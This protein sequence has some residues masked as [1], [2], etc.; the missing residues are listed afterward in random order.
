MRLRF[1]TIL[2]LLTTAG[3]AFAQHPHPHHHGESRVI[4]FPDVQGY[5]TLSVDL[6][7]HTVFSDGSV[8]PTIRAEEAIR[9]GLD[10]VAITDHLE[11]QPHQDDIPHPNRNRSYEIARASAEGHDLIV[12]NGSEV[13]REMPPGHANA[14]FVEDANRLLDDDAMTVFREAE[15]QGAFTFWNHP[16]WTAQ[17]PSGIASLTD[18]HRTLIQEG[19]L[20][21]IEVV[22]EHTYSAEALQIALDH[23]LTIVG[24][25]DI[26]GLIDWD[27]EV[28]HGGHRPVTLAFVNERSAEGLQEALQA[29]R[30]A[31]WYDNLLIG[32]E[33]HVTRLLDAALIIEQAQYQGDTSVLDVHIQ[34]RS[35]AA[36]I[37]DRRTDYTFHAQSDVVE[38]PPHETTR[39]QVKTETR[40]G[41][42]TLAFDVLNAVTAPETHPTITWDV[43]VVR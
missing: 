26:H 21:G 14:V 33:E 11:Y 3:G 29:G 20:D 38:I 34:N 41:E 6:H 40:R 25:S 37:L 43:S 4:D 28:H 7:T 39:L 5:E 12:I 31:V 1:L 2:L 19:L 10:A 35:D 18:M 27:Y 30:T 22:N 24:T 42:V 16:M 15:R 36:F 9:D 17:Q 32:R 13:T 8:W 23:D